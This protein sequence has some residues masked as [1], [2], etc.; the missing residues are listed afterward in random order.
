MSGLL[1]PYGFPATQAPGTEGLGKNVDT[2]TLTTVTPNGIV[3]T[4]AAL[5]TQITQ[6][7]QEGGKLIFPLW[8][9]SLNA[10]PNI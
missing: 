6:T 4:P 3:E 2:T 5:Q 1:V 8:R 9:P 10:S 7:L